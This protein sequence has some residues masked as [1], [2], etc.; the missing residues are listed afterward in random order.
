MIKKTK[1]INIIIL[2]IIF[3]LL[4]SIFF[5]IVLS[6]KIKPILIETAKSEASKLESNIVNKA[7]NELLNEGY[8]TNNLFDTIKSSTGTIET[9]DFNS[10]QVNKLLSKLTMKVQDDLIG[11]ESGIVED[12][13]INSRNI[14]S[15]HNI[16]LK[17]GIVLEIPLGVLSSNLILADLGPRIPI[18]LHYLNDVNSY[19]NT[20]IREYGINNALMEIY[21]NVEVNV[22]ILL[23]FISEKIVLTTSVPIA[24]KMIQGKIPTY[25]G[26]TISKDSN[27]F[28][29][30]LE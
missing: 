27:L 4:F 23:P 9:I 17:K 24:I 13:G 1:S 3:S 5:L 7:I 26:N 21:V 6:T 30:P 2:S 18:K 15:T 8:D 12:L 28:S 11:L 25:Y 16:N 10:N 14:V 29:L 19:I 22:K 20:K